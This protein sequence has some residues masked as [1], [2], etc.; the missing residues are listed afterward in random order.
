M[1]KGKTVILADIPKKVMAEATSLLESL[2]QGADTQIDDNSSKDDLENRMPGYSFLTNTRDNHFA[3]ITRF[4]SDRQYALGQERG[5]V[6]WNAVLTGDWMRKVQELNMCLIFLIHLGSGQ[7]AWGTEILG[8][9]FRNMQNV[10]RSLFMT[11][12]GL[13]TIIGYNKTNSTAGVE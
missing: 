13:A 4:L 12:D 3:L 11:P 8:I 2:T 7:P 10:H 5:E 6:K 9:L 1:V